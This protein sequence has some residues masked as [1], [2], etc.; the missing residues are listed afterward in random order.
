M[1]VS[2]PITLE[3]GPCSRSYPVLP[4][5]GLR[6]TPPPEATCK[7]LEAILERLGEIETPADCVGV[8]TQHNLG[9]SSPPGRPNTNPPRCPPHP[10]EAILAGLE[11]NTRTVKRV[12]SGRRKIEAAVEAS[13]GSLDHK[14]TS[15]HLALGGQVC[16]G[17]RG[18]RSPSRESGTGGEKSLTFEVST[19]LRLH[20]THPAAFPAIC[21]R[22]LLSLLRI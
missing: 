9:R 10:I 4:R 11:T 12:A 21:G 7:P 19:A 15:V 3:P 5:T 6:I 22:M 16:L 1:R 18:G 20:S 13:L 2:A 17:Y 8:C 14:C